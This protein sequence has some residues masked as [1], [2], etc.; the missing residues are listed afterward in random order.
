M[1]YSIQKTNANFFITHK[2]HFDSTLISLLEKQDSKISKL[3]NEIK[4]Y[5]ANI[6]ISNNIIKTKSKRGRTAQ[7]IPTL[8]FYQSEIDSYLA[9]DE[10]K[11]KSRNR[12]AKAEGVFGDIRQNFDFTRLLRRRG[13]SS[14]KLEINMVAIEFNIRKYHNKKNKEIVH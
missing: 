8:E 3:N 2:D 12:S 6:K 10:G 7:I 4:I 5:A 9:T 13:M 1:G 11:E 14:V